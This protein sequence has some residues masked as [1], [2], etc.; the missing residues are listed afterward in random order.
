LLASRL[1]GGKSIRILL[2]KRL[3][4]ASA[5]AYSLAADKQNPLDYRMKTAAV[6][7]GILLGKRL[8]T[9]QTALI[10]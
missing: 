5:P 10:R 4:L 2:G 7:T 6:S 1:A 3:Y 8:Y 9:G